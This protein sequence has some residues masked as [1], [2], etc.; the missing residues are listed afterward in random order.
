M[1]NLRTILDGLDD[2]ELDYVM[3]RS[4][5]SKDTAAYNE[6]GISRAVW[7]SWDKDRRDYLNEVALQL[8]RNR[9]VAAEMVLIENAEKAARV[10]ADKLDSR[11][12]HIQIKAAEEILDRTAGRPTQKQ[13]VDV[14]TGGQPVEINVRYVN[15]WSE[16][17]NDDAD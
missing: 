8:K 16:D 3:E 14:T 4:K 9:A 5:V 15:H 10:M 1:D 12:E 11:K 7:F 6:A 2:R 13:Q 17:D